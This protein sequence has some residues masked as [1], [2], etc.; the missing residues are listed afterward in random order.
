MISISKILKCNSEKYDPIE[1]QLLFNKTFF[2]KCRTI[3]IYPLDTLQ[4]KIEK[5]YPIFH[6]FKNC[7][8]I[9]SLRDH[10]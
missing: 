10:L 4:Q 6:F 7:I 8:K 9:F 5:N 2:A 1:Q 3:D